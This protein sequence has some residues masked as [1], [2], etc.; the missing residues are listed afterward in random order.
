MRSAVPE[1]IW[2]SIDPIV[3]ANIRDMLR[4]QVLAARDQAERFRDPESKHFDALMAS[5]WDDH[6]RIYDDAHEILTGSRVPR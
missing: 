2:L 4:G 3:R 1:A 5:R 6:E